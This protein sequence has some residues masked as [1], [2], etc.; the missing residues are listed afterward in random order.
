MLKL[1]KRGGIIDDWLYDYKRGLFIT[2]LAPDTKRKT[3]HII[4]Y[5]RVTDNAFRVIYNVSYRP[6]GCEG[7]VDLY[8]LHEFYIMHYPC[9]VELDSY[10]LTDI[11]NGN[12][13]E[14]THIGQHI[15]PQRGVVAWA[16]NPDLI[17]KGKAATLCVVK[18]D[19][20]NVVL[21]GFIFNIKLSEDQKLVL[22]QSGVFRLFSTATAYRFTLDNDLV[23]FERHAT[24]ME[25]H[26]HHYSPN[27]TLI[28][29]FVSKT[30]I[31][32]GGFEY[33]WLEREQILIFF[34]T[35]AGK[36]ATITG[37]L[38]LMIPTNPLL[39]QPICIQKVKYEMRQP[40]TGA[41]LKYVKI[42]NRGDILHFVVKLKV[43][44]DTKMCTFIRAR[45]YAIEN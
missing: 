8:W 11:R 38:F 44:N 37:V 19:N 41:D 21:S 13:K 9:G 36:Y 31:P 29:T 22:W 24:K 28:R 4:T 45:S 16:R 10:R 5:S 7:K 42:G 1:E 40:I 2:H 32:G 43:V 23:V 33:Q 39:S 18:L 26:R 35:R 20:G 6:K 12:M 3:A 25:F 17:Y 15:C 34:R 30:W 27:N 14:L